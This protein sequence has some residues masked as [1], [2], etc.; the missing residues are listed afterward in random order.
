MLQALSACVEGNIGRVWAGEEDDLTTAYDRNF[1]V[2][3]CDTP[4]LLSLAKRLRYQVYCVENPF[5]DPANNPDG[6]ERDA[7][8]PHSV[9]SLLSHRGTGCLVGAVRLILPRAEAPERSFPMQ[10]VCSDPAL[11]DP[12][13]FPAARAAEVSRFC[14][15]KDFRRRLGESRYADVGEA[16]ARARKAEERRLMPYVTLGLIRGLLR[17]SI[18]HGVRHWAIVV[19]PP[20][21]RLLKTLGFVF[22]EIG[23]LVEHHGLRQPCHSDLARLL[24]GVRRLRPDVWDVVTERGRLWRALFEPQLAAA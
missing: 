7:F 2:R 22:Q 13:I 6:Q 23:P 5:E 4:E 20:L 21:L 3:S 16:E 10:E 8:D 15:S 11:A 12:Q 1:A 9:H 19:E 18:D 17:M 24:E 14:V